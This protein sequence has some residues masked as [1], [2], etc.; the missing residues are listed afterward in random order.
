MKLNDKRMKKFLA[1]ASTIAVMIGGVKNVSAAI[2]TSNNNVD[3]NAPSGLAAAFN[4]GD[5]L[6][7]DANRNIAFNKAALDV[8]G[9]NLATFTGTATLSENT[10]ISGATTNPGSLPITFSAAKA[11]TLS[12][13]GKYRGLSVDFGNNANAR[14]NV[15]ANVTEINGDITSTAG[16]TGQVVF[17]NN[18]PLTVTG[19]IGDAGSLE[20]MKL[21]GNNVSIIGK[22]TTAAIT[23]SNSNKSNTLELTDPFILGVVRTDYNGKGI[24]KFN[25]NFGVQGDYGTVNSVLDKVIMSGDN[26]LT[27]NW[28]VNVYAKICAETGGENSL[29]LDGG[30]TT[31]YAVGTSQADRLKEIYAGSFSGNNIFQSNVYTDL[32]K[33]A[34]VHHLIFH[35]SVNADIIDFDGDNSGPYDATI[36]VGANKDFAVKNMINLVSGNGIGT[37]NLNG[38]RTIS[39]NIG[40]NNRYLKA[41]NFDAATKAQLNADIYAQT[42]SAA[43][44]SFTILKDVTMG[45]AGGT[46]DL[47]GSTLNVATNILRLDSN[48]TLSNAST[49]MLAYKDSTMGSVD[50]RIN[51]NVVTLDAV[52][53][54]VSFLSF[55]KKSETFTIFKFGQVP[56]IPNN[57]VLTNNSSITTFDIV[58][59]A[60]EIKLVI[61]RIKDLEDFIDD[62]V[63][64]PVKEVVEQLQDYFDDDPTGQAENAR[65][66]FTSMWGESR[67]K[68]NRAA[69]RFV[70]N[71]SAVKATRDITAHLVV[72]ATRTANSV[73]ESRVSSLES[74]KFA[75]NTGIAAGDSENKFG[76]WLKGFASKISQ[77]MRKEEAGYNGQV[78]GATIGFDRA[79]NERLIAGV[80]FLHSDADL[81]HSNYKYGDKSNSKT[82]ILSVYA[83]YDINNNMFAQAAVNTGSSKVVH[84]DQKILHGARAIAYGR[85]NIFTYGMH[86]LVGYNFAATKNIVIT[87]LMGLH[88]QTFLESNYTEIGAGPLNQRVSKRTYDKVIG[89]AG[90]KFAK[91]IESNNRTI[92]PE[93]HG[94]INHDFRNKRAK[95]LSTL[96]G[97]GGFIYTRGEKAD[98]TS[99]NLG[100]G[101]STKSGNTELGIE[102]NSEIKSKYISHQGSF[103]LRVSL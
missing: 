17:E 76:L 86:A 80:A 60:K 50:N 27:V 48:I 52:K 98:P 72:N 51:N 31:I 2:V 89:K 13:T 82:N 94:Y 62:D 49:V 68:L 36:T 79:L 24:L 54:D 92:T 81:K 19:K 87:P 95:V 75:E 93:I 1:T 46:I 30:G 59:D 83:S 53:L 69:E 15:G 18:N 57:F 58:H 65:N 99:Y 42:I 71:T 44:A 100:L 25:T 9:I 21:K 29:S 37:L 14:L 101:V 4:N 12:G 47:S 70:I 84:K 3:F 34:D 28:G 10:I 43:S 85:Y 32:I 77:K 63:P 33:I 26:T 66:E 74:S 41:L 73:I 40:S 67:D 96:D 97:L 23:F 8:G 35:G 16:G 64:P 91:N 5:I 7:L 55:P 88:Y 78:G 45:V 103:K 38:T 102:Y 61:S 56:V 39:Y 22:V 6:Q 11:L 20:Y 90:V